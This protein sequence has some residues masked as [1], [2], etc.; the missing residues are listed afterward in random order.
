MLTLH[1]LSQMTWQQIQYSGRHGLGSEKISRSEIK[2][3][4][5]PHEITEDT[6][7]LAIRFCALA[8]MVGYRVGQV[9]H[10]LWLDRAF[11]LYKH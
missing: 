3:A 4:P 7:L 9:F 10:V 2:G 1:R 6:P 5:I 11:T 8:P